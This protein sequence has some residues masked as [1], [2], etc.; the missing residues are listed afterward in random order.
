MGVGGGGEN[1]HI[2]KSSSF[3]LNMYVMQCHA[4]Q[5]EWNGMECKVK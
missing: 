3:F 1:F 5:M 4:M 2:L